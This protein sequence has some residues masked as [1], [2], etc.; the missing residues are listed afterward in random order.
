MRAKQARALSRTGVG[1]GLL[2]AFIIG[3]GLNIQGRDAGILIALGIVFLLAM[4][5]QLVILLILGETANERDE[6]K[7]A[8]EYVASVSE[9][10]VDDLIRQSAV[11]EAEITPIRAVQE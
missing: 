11:P 5:F 8:L 3:L 1:L 10:D 2:G 7:R 6:Y 9:L 4:I